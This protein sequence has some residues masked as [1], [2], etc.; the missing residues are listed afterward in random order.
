[1]NITRKGK[2]KKLDTALKKILIPFLR[3]K[4]FKGSVPHFRRFQNDR[5]N[6]LTFQHSLYDTKFVIEIANCPI[7]GTRMHWG[8]EIQPNK[9]TAHHMTDRL[10][11]GSIK[12]KRDY[13][14]DF[15]LV[16]IVGDVYSKTA[17]EIISLWNE[18]ENWWKEDPYKQRFYKWPEKAP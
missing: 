17:N 9:C 5:I 18:A 14:F 8:E 1:M 4:G 11:L 15:G 16:L 2:R 10:R 12:N 3:E 7:E 6:L 13:W